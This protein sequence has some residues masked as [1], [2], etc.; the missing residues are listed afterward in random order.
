MSWSLL[1]QKFFVDALEEWRKQ[2][3]I[4]RFVLVGHSL[5]AVISTAYAVE[6]GTC[7]S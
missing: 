3:K 7:P 6:V 4:Q 2:M 5:G 1:V